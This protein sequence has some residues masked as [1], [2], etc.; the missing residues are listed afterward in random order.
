M[1]GVRSKGGNACFQQQMLTF[2]CHCARAERQHV[3]QLLQ[4]RQTFAYLLRKASDDDDDADADNATTSP[5]IWTNS[6]LVCR[7]LRPTIMVG[8][9]RA[10]LS[11][12]SNHAPR[13]A[14]VGSNLDEVCQGPP[15]DAGSRHAWHSLCEVSAQSGRDS[16][17][18]REFAPRPARLP[19]CPKLSVGDSGGS[20]R[21]E[22]VNVISGAD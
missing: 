1:G 9:T 21:G 5:W 6:T 8:T 19:T 16:I 22:P 13:P 3:N 17:T 12:K 4:G 11:G 14:C 2:R 10:V 7:I 20:R 18:S 15:D